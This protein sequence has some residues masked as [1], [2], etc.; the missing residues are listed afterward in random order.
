MVA[1]ALGLAVVS[2]FAIGVSVTRVLMAERDARDLPRL[3]ASRSKLPAA[4]V[5]GA[6]VFVDGP[7]PELTA[8]LEHCLM[9]SDMGLV[10]TIVVSGGV[11]GEFDEVEV[12][13]T[14][15]QRHGVPPGRI[16]EARPG[17]NTR[18]SVEAAAALA[19]AY[20][21]DSFI[22]V[23]TRFHAR[24]IR[25]EARRAR[26]EMLVT[27]PEVSPETSHLGVRRMRIATE[28]IASM[29]YA[30]PKTWTT[31]IDTTPGTWRHSIPNRCVAV[32]GMQQR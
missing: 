28:V 13:S 29:F 22:A 16:L 21:L 6:R 10:D 25:D 9:L 7:S 32:L 8:R 5:F 15:L 20:D 26:I 23:S 12:M 31:R 24:R 19:H 3:L 30:L 1:T 2:G 11:D 4:L 14:W 18:E 27:G 17:S